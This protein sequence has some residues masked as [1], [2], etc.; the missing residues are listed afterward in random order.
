MEETSVAQGIK[1]VKTYD[2][3][4]FLRKRLGYSIEK[5]DSIM[6]TGNQTKYTWRRNGIRP[7]YQILATCL[8]INPM[9]VEYA[10]EH[11]DIKDYDGII[12]LKNQEKY[13]LK[14]FNSYLGI[15]GKETLY[16]WKNQRKLQ[17]IHIHLVNILK[18]YPDLVKKAVTLLWY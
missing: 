13:S 12:N 8:S 6:G 7:V 10:I 16:T 11:G 1:V 9:E 17:P 3:Y 14:V 5:F 4:L 15:K 2:D 18:L